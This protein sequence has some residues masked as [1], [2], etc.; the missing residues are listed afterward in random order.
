MK[1]S[2]DGRVL[3][4]E[5][6][7]FYPNMLA[8]RNDEAIYHRLL[9]YIWELIRY[10]REMCHMD[11][12]YTEPN[13]FSTPVLHLISSSAEALEGAVR[14]YE[15]GLSS[16]VATLARSCLEK[17]ASAYY[18]SGG[19]LDE[20]IIGE[21]NYKEAITERR[22]ATMSHMV[23]RF[24]LQASAYPEL[25][26][27]WLEINSICDSLGKELE[28]VSGRKKHVY[29]DSVR[30]LFKNCG[31]GS[32][33]AAGYSDACLAAHYDSEKFCIAY[34]QHGMDLEVFAMAGVR[35]IVQAS[36]VLAS[37]VRAADILAEDEI[38]VC[39]NLRRKMEASIKQLSVSED[40]TIARFKRCLGLWV[41]G[42]KIYRTEAG[43][44]F[45]VRQHDDHVAIAF[46]TKGL[47]VLPSVDDLAS[48]KIYNA[49]IEQ[50]KMSLLV[51]YRLVPS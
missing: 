41:K 28:K 20:N 4:E 17:A 12:G 46:S 10:S 40:K 48:I 44:I 31:L 29:P 5:L 42:Y 50:C 37:C 24:R 45:A 32:L 30:K 33:Y 13:V 15:A 6:E 49:K 36:Y 18:A 14:C 25:S 16:S 19:G 9:P 39:E 27:R 47:R 21:T 3:F 23:N 43:F 7:E 35:L 38:E 22:M 11:G 8:V 51:R 2:L 1:A 34:S 26:P